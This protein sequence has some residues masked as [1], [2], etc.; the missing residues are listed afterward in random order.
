MSKGS[1]RRPED[2]ERFC[3]NWERLFG[4]PDDRS[5]EGASEAMQAFT[6]GRR[7]A[8]EEGLRLHVKAEV[9]GS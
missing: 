8:G 1:T 5:V 9:E 6:S 2:Y 7:Q 4:Q 3:K